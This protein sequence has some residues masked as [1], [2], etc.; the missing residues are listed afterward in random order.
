MENK[1]TNE[2]YKGFNTKGGNNTFT[3]N[4]I[5]VYSDSDHQPKPKPN[6]PEPE[7]KELYCQFLNKIKEKYQ[8]FKLFHTQEKVKL[9]DQYIPI[10]V[11]L[12]RRFTHEIETLK[13]YQIADLDSKDAYAIKG[14]KKQEEKE[15]KIKIA[16]V[17][18]KEAKKDHKKI[19]VLAD[20]GM[21]KSTLLK[22]ETIIKVK[23]ELDN[24]DNKSIDDLVFPLFIRLSELARETGEIID[25]IPT[26]L[27][28]DY[29]EIIDKIEYY[30]QEKLKQGKCLLLLDALDEVPKNDR[31]PLSEKLN[32]FLKNYP[33]HLICT[34][35]I[36][37]YGG[38]F[39]DGGKEVEIVPFDDKKTA[40]YIKTW[41]DYAAGKIEDETVS[42]DGLINELKNKPQIQGLAQNP[43]L[44][45]LLCSLY[46][47]KGLILPARRTQVYEKAV[48]YMLSQWSKD[49]QR[50]L[51]D[52]GWIIA[53]K[54]LLEYLAYK[55]SCQ[56]QEVFSKEDLYN[57]INEYL[58]QTD[59][60]EFKEKTATEL[61]KELTEEDGIIQTLSADG[62]QYLFLHRTFQ[63]Y[64]TASYLKEKIEKNEQEGL[65]LI[66]AHFWEYDWHETIILTAGLLKN[67]IL[68]LTKLRRE[69]DDIF[70][71]M[72]LLS[73]SCLTECSTKLKGHNNDAL[74]QRIIDDIFKF[75][76]KYPRVDFITSVLI[77]LGKIGSKTAVN[78]LIKAL[79]HS[80]S[81]VRKNAAEALGKIGSETAVNPL[82]KALSHSD[83]WVRKNAAEALG[84]I[85]SETAVNPLIKAL[86]DSDSDVRYYAAKA[87]G[88]IGSETAVNP[89]IKALSDSYSLVRKNAAEAL[90]K[91][92]SKTAVQPLIKALSDSDRLVR[93]NAAKAL[94]NIGSETAVNPLI[95]ALSDSYSLVRWNAAEALGKIGSETAVNALIKALSHSDSWVRKNA[96]EALGKI[97]SETAVNPL[98]KALSDS[99]SLVRWN[100]AE[101]LGKIGS[102]TAVNPLIKALSHSDSLLRNNAAEALGKIGSETAVNALIKALSHSSIWVRNNAAEALGKIGSET[103]VNALIKALSDSDSWVRNKAAEALGKIGSETAVNP[104]IKALSHSSYNLSSK[105]AEALVKIG[106][107][108]AVNALIKA[109][110][111]SNYD[112]RKNAAEALGKIGSKTAVQPLIKA[113]SDSDRLVRKNAAEALGNIGSETAVNP[114]IKALSDS[115]R[116]VRKNAAKALGKIGSKTAVNPLIKA[117]SDSDSLVRWNATEALV[118]IGSKIAVNAL[119]TALSDSDSWVRKNAAE[120]LGKIGSETAVNPLIKAL[121]DSDRWVRYYA[122]KALGK[123]GSETAVNPLIKALSDFNR[124]VRKNAAE[125]L[126][127][128]GSETAV[129]PL[130]KALSDFNRDVR[131]NAAE[132]LGKIDSPE[133]LEQMIKNQNVDI[134]EESNFIHARK[135]AIRYSRD[136]L[137]FIPVY[138]RLVRYL[139]ITRVIKSVISR[140]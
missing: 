35:R 118:K 125:A 71:T 104:L 82:I 79:S 122:A 109:L 52:D 139:P 62:N 29:S 25:I 47:S 124:D 22:H 72:L 130:I 123:I 70:K 32:R 31:I 74:V 102:E 77:S 15:Q 136:N 36:V 23:E 50:K 91:I 81:W 129:K 120:A 114:L 111:H 26:I 19:M 30:L 121:S 75:W 46:Q 34:S 85:G 95:K 9:Q 8:Y 138:P 78:A 133:I 116:D 42:A 132:A 117:L 86:S 99:Y 92:G 59:K 51:L 101:A 10:Q 5:N 28:Q 128:I 83:S 63:E 87:L 33:C 94:G 41:F 6:L 2:N 108:T 135:L 67:P 127:K 1:E 80:D 48:N 66:Q 24:L 137:P 131:K 110:S 115:N 76:Y 43:L 97:G 55:F 69:K 106:S 119:I 88:N 40:D 107:E 112:V 140:Q 113:L 68:L 90:G 73:G 56:N 17:D 54:N 18:W 45:S 105:A 21:G 16:K 12:E 13:N 84:K 65:Q 20:P 100:A 27:K 96:A 57:K 64:F 7:L 89:L 58:E 3:H 98:I 49:N 126:G 44:L 60:R 61:M 38:K 103:A 37:G 39:I 4:T 53:K 14:I 134:Y 93:K 11:T